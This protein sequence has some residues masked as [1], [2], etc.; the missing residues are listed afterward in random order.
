MSIGEIC[1]R[2]TVFT[3]KDSS[4]SQAAQLMREQ[5]VGDLV[6]VEE[7]GG[8]RIPVGILTDRD[9]VIEILAKNVDMNAVTVGDIMSSELLTARESD[10]L[11]ETLQRM[12]A[13][14]V[15]RVPVVDTGGVLAGIIS[16]DDLLDLLADELTTL[17]RLLSRGQARERQKRT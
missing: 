15:R 2:E 14:G 3:T 10:G 4:I 9:L 17:A 13:K 8:R 16:A 5:H 6:V 1:N 12:R 7:K 11:Y